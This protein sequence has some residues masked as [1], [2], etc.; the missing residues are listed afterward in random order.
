MPAP[1]VSAS[2]APPL[3]EVAGLRKDYPMAAAKGWRRG[4][5][6]SPHAVDGV[7]LTI[8][9]GETVGLVGESGCCQSSMSCHHKMAQMRPAV[10]AASN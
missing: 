8:G 4:P 1:A 2:I 3:L 6:S 5:A 9:E 7:G 10:I